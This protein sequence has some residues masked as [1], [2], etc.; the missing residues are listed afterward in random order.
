MPSWLRWSRSRSAAAV[1]SPAAGRA[2]VDVAIVV[3]GKPR[4]VVPVSFEIADMESVPMNLAGERT[5]VRTALYSA[6]VQLSAADPRPAL[7]KAR[8][9]V[10]LIAV[11]GTARLE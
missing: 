6:P 7:I 10:K 11:I 2:V 4:E 1:L 8:D 5:G 9:N 3:K